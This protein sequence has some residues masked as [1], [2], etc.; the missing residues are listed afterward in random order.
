MHPTGLQTGKL[1]RKMR[2]AQFDLSADGV[3]MYLDSA[4]GVLQNVERQ[5]LIRLNAAKARFELVLRGRVMETIALEGDV[6]DACV[7]A[8]GAYF[9]AF[10]KLC[11]KREAG[12]AAA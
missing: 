5:I 3:L 8:F 6:A 1:I 11:A 4:I 2:A 7:Q 10:E 9:R 12:A